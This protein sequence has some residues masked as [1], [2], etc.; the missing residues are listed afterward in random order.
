LQDN[1]ATFSL[2]NRVAPKLEPEIVFKLSAPLP[3]GSEDAAKVLEAVEW[4]ALGFEIVDCHY[5][6]WRYKAPDFVA[7][8]GF[9]VALI[10]GEPHPVSE[11]SGLAEQL[12]NCKLKLFKNGEPVAEGGGKNVLENPA[13]SL[14]CLAGTLAKQPGAATLAAGEVITSGTMTDAQFVAAGEEWVA[15]LEGLALPRLTINFTA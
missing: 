14:G 1:K 10:I 9:H 3:E 5:S 8:F 15:E 4:I 6:G 11:F 7:D 13:L 12:A 2:A